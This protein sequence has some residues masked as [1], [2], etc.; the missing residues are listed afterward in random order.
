VSWL[1]AQIGLCLLLAALAGWFIGWRL[2]G[3]RDQ[4][5]IEDLR[6][7]MLATKDAHDREVNESRRRVE[8][9]ESRLARAADTSRGRATANAPRRAAP[10]ETL[11]RLE[12]AQ[13][14]PV[15]TPPVRPRIAE[16]AAATPEAGTSPAARADVAAPTHVAAAE[17]ERRREAEAALRR[18]TAAVLSFQSEIEALREAV[19]E[20]AAEMARLEDRLAGSAAAAE[21]LAGA[22]A[23]AEA[24]EAQLRKKQAEL[25]RAE[26]A[27]AAQ[28]VAEQELRQE[29]ALRE[30]RINELR[31]RCAEIESKLLAATE[32]AASVA[33]TARPAAESKALAEELDEAR[34][35]LQRQIERNRKQEAVHRAVVQQLET[36]K[37]RLRT[38]AASAA[39]A[40]SAPS[41]RQPVLEQRSDELAEILGIGPVYARQL[42]ALGVDTYAQIAAWTEDDIEEIARGLATYPKRIRS[43]RWIEQAQ[44]LAQGS[45]ARAD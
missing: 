45:R 37:A 6:Q 18:K 43:G 36:D 39:P 16:L 11:G 44:A 22:R 12:T 35:L 14:E 38:A 8:E 42:R 32:E 7:T 30:T 31:N 28:R 40:R 26:T 2:R 5:R 17:R 29:I 27:A 10:V 41:P 9:L 24:I 21:E 3:F 19:A 1:L 4:D 13:P 20:K 25:E 33:A 34:R 23:H 15:E